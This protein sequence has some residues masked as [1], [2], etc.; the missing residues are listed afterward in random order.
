MKLDL[1][2]MMTRKYFKAGD[3]QR[4]GQ[5]FRER[6]RLGSKGYAELVL[7]VGDVQTEVYNIP[8]ERATLVVEYYF[9]HKGERIETESIM[10]TRG[11]VVAPN[12]VRVVSGLEKITKIK[13]E[14]VNDGK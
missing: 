4:E 1:G 14:L 3:T 12:P 2:D 6:L 11:L 8:N 9:G 13:L 7:R 10:L 5:D